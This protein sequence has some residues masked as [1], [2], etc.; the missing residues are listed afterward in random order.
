MFGNDMQEMQDYRCRDIVLPC[1]HLVSCEKCASS[2]ENCVTCN[3]NILG[4]VRTYVMSAKH[5]TWLRARARARVR[6]A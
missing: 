1:R 2:M 5:K 3:E 4:T 6:Q